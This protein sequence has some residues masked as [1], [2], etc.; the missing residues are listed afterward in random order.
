MLFRH[1][2]PRGVAPGLLKRLDRLLDALD[3]AERAG[4]MNM[5]GN[6]FHELKG[7]RKGT[8]SVTVSGNW[9]LTFRFADADAFGVDL[10]DYH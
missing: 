9:R 4:D 5:P 7:E 3:S 2:D 1:N 8:Y 6:R 10:E